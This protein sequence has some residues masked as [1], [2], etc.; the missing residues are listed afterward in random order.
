MKT[1][2]KITVSQTYE[3]VW[4][5]PTPATAHENIL[6]LKKKNKKTRVDTFY[7]LNTL[8]KKTC[9]FIFYSFLFTLPITNFTYFISK[10]LEKEMATHSSIPAWEIPHRSLVG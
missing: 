6:S 2:S 8:S 10:A 9:S 4:L 3:Y 5:A 1:R 7:T